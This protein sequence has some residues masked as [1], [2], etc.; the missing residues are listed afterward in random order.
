[1]GLHRNFHA[2][3]FAFFIHK[4]F[5]V[6]LQEKSKNYF[7]TGFE[8]H[9]S[10]GNLGVCS[11]IAILIRL[12]V[13]A[14]HEIPARLVSFFETIQVIGKVRMG[15]LLRFFSV[16]HVCVLS[17]CQATEAAKIKN[18]FLLP[19]VFIFCFSPD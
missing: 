16:W 2:L 3:C 9:S 17:F 6:P 10:A 8:F 1:M 18:T 14:T 15:F 13:Q 5:K 4:N 7:K 19:A 12:P 11:R